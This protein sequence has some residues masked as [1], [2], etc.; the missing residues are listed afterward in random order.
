MHLKITV[1]LWDF[2]SE[3]SLGATVAESEALY[4]QALAKN[5]STIL[6]L[7]HEPIG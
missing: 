5:P 7:N 6:A 2:D 1:A 3:D 4:D